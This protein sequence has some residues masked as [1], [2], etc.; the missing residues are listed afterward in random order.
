MSLDQRLV[1]ASQDATSPNSQS[2]ELVECRYHDGTQGSRSSLL[3]V[4][5]LPV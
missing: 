1:S 3:S 5:V 4:E 2:R